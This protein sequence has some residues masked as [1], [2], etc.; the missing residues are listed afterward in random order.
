MDEKRIYAIIPARYASSRLPGKPLA[1]ICGRPMIQRVIERVKAIPCIH[2]VA[3]ATDNTEIAAC[4]SGIGESAIMTNPGH[5][6]G[7]DRVAEA[8]R[9]LGL[10]GE[11]IVV[12]IQGDQP[13]LEKKAVEAVI[14]MLRDSA[15]ISMA[16]AACPMEIIEAENPNRVK[17]V[18]DRFSRAIYFSRA[19]IPFDRDGILKDQA[20]PYL[21]HI[22]IYAFR[23]RFLQRFVSL[24][25]GR[26]E[27]VERLEQ[28]RAVENGYEIGV[29]IVEGVLP[30]VDT[31]EDL[32]LVRRLFSMGQDA[33]ST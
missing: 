20:L 13:L 26:L 24:P 19:A 16:T 5:P 15:G 8:A 2:R 21:R 3:V 30:E 31:R 12:N 23:N 25:E 10:A 22:G 6:S 9:I 1:D 18:V 28:L 7:T 33:D 29:S 17:V 4:V 27:S 11:D 32:E 14:Q